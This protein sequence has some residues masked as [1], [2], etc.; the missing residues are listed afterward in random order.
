MHK[1][2]ELHIPL[3]E[4]IAGS[5][6]S[7]KFKMHTCPTCPSLL[8]NQTSLPLSENVCAA[9]ESTNPARV[10]RIGRMAYI[11]GVGRLSPIKLRIKNVT[12]PDGT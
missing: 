6:F 8:H 12:F 4:V 3:Q 7:F 1:I 9:D 11:S 10:F 5:Y 2:L